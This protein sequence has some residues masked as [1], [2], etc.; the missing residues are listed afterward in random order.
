MPRRCSRAVGLA[1]A[2]LG[3]APAAALA[4]AQSLSYGDYQVHD[5]RVDARLR[6]AALDLADRVQLARDSSGN[7]TPADVERVAPAIF[8]ATLAQV[9]ASSE[10]N[11]CVLQPVHSVSADGKDGLVITGSFQCSGDVGALELKLGFIAELPSGHTHLSLIS[12]D[13]GAPIERLAQAGSE[14]MIAQRQADLKSTLGKLFLLGVRH[15]FTGYDH[16]AFLIGLL[17]L[18]GTLRRLIGIVS[19]FTVAHSIT[20]ALAALNIFAPPPQLIEPSIALSIIF[21]AGEDLWALRNAGGAGA[22]GGRSE[23]ALRHRWMITFAFGLIH[24]F[25]FAGAL[26]E[27][28]LPRGGLAAS[29]VMFNLGVE[30]GQICIVALVFPLLKQVRRS[31]RT[32]R[33]VSFA[34]AAIIGLLGAFWLVQRLFLIFTGRSDLL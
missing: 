7:F 27:L 17:L 24:G 5:A 29:L 25:G 33:V 23:L 9:S 22:Q 14:V 26:R 1:L 19:A 15:I 20:L 12:F 31:A 18:G 21:I 4:H 16:I 13:G 8:A 11:S 32:G 3:L 34:L 28:H 10:K 30:A 6:F 2:V